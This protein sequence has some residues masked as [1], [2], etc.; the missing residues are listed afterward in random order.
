[1][2]RKTFMFALLAFWLCAA[3]AQALA[4]DFSGPVL[5]V[6]DG[7]TI[8]VGG[9][10]GEVKVRLY[11]V[12]CPEAGQPF[13]DKARRFTII[14]AKGRTV[15]VHGFYRDQYGRLVARVILQ[16]GR[17]LGLELIRAGLAWWYRHYAPRDTEAAAFER[18]ARQAGRGLWSVP[19]AV[20]PWD[21]R[22]RQP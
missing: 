10:S 20:A 9:P 5:W 16:D 7:D 8:K 22:P 12:D 17:D 18:E 1:M 2:Q 11:R 19:D 4:E 6:Y 13:A 3:A 14:N 21:Y 15:A